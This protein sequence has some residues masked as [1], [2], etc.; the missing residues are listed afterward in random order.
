MNPANLFLDNETAAA[1]TARAT[2]LKVAAD[3]A[4]VCTR[5]GEDLEAIVC[6]VLHTSD[7]PPPRL[8]PGDAVLVW[9]SGDDGVVLGRIGGSRAAAKPKEKPEELVIEAKKGLT[10]RCGDGSITL[11]ADG[12]ILIKGQDLVSH[13]RRLNRIKGGSVAIN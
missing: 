13:A 9:L 10:L 4:V 6:Q 8:A 7:G 2:V 12:K 3:G 11:R 1:Q 5:D